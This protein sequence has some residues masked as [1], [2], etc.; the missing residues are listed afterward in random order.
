MFKGGIS[1]FL[2]C[3]LNV[4]SVLRWPYLWLLWNVGARSGAEWDG[5]SGWRSRGVTVINGIWN[6]QRVTSEST[7]GISEGVDEVKERWYTRPW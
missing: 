2:R 1:Q 4:S 3:G 7:V 5:V 6:L